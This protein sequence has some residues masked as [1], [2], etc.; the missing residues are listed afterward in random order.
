[1][2]R[3]RQKVF[4]IKTNKS[5]NLFDSLPLCLPFGRITAICSRQNTRKDLCSYKQVL[6]LTVEILQRAKEECFNMYQKVIARVYF[7]PKV[8]MFFPV[9]SSFHIYIYIHIYVCVY[10]Y[11]HMCIFCFVFL[12][13]PLAILMV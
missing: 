8:G 1:M 5:W 10:I 11:T 9:I 3:D 12:K 6:I 7:F 2:H 4:N 13:Q